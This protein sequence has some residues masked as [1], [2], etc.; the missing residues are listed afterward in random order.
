MIDLGETE[1]HRCWDCG[2]WIESMSGDVA[3]YICNGCRVKKLAAATMTVRS[4]DEAF[5]RMDDERRN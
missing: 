4:L 1:L 5:K 3:T 2:E